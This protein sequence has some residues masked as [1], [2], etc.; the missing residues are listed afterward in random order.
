MKNFKTKFHGVLAEVSFILLL[1]FSVIYFNIAHTQELKD[2]AVYKMPGPPMFCG[3]QQEL[4]ETLKNLKEE[5]FVVLT[6]VEI[7]STEP[8][9]ILYRN[10]STGSWSIVIYN[11]RGAPP[12]ISCLLSGGPKSYILPNIDDIIPM[13]EKQN[14]GLDPYKPLEEDITS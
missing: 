13:I 9:Q 4:T 11:I 3:V 5:E 1:I 2:T 8:Y 14:N 12:N 6:G 10:I 7:S